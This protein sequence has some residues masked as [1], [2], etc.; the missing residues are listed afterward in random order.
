MKAGTARN[1]RLEEDLLALYER[2]RRAR[3]PRA[4]EHVMQALEAL[5]KER[6]EAQEALDRA[7][8]GSSVTPLLPT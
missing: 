8:L 4:A 5:A 6:P 2:C 7:Y 1:L 3:C